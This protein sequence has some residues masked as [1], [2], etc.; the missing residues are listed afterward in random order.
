M[1]YRDKL[2]KR[3]TR[4]AWYAKNREK[5]RTYMTARRRR[6]G[7]KAR[8]NDLTGRRF[9]KLFIEEQHSQKANNGKSRWICLC[10]CGNKTIVEVSSLTG[11]HTKS[12]GCLQYIPKPDTAFRR[13]FMSYVHDAR[14]AGR[15][16]LLTEAQARKYFES[17]CSYCGQPPSTIQKSR[18]E[19]YTFT[20][21]D[22]ID[23]SK[24]YSVGNCVPCCKVCNR[25]KMDMGYE[26]FMAH[27]EKILSFRVSVRIA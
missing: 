18:R 14:K 2:K 17:C 23:S 7:A 19:I 11:G 3:A 26:E 21:I 9:G 20:G 12:C 25:M 5:L 4:Q 22:R 8:D 13:I 24:G 1:P 6:L 10:D 15:E 16:F 27:I